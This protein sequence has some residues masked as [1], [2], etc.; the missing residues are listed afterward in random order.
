[1][2]KLEFT[3][4]F[5]LNIIASEKR[6]IEKAIKEALNNGENIKITTMNAQIAYFYLN[7]EDAREAIGASYVIPDGTGLSWA[8]RRL[9]GVNIARYP[10]V[11]LLLEICR[12]ASELSKKAYILGGKPGV[13]EKAAEN[14]NEKTGINICGTH[15]GYF[16]TE[17]ETDRIC[18]EIRSKAPSV[19]FVGLGAPKQEKWIYR[20]FE[21]TGCSLAIGVGGSLDIYAQTAKRAPLWIQKANLEWLYRILQ[22]PVT[23]AKVILQIASFVM[24]VLRE[25]GKS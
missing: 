25:K 3:E 12:S 4:F 24:D 17:T 5:G 20:N 16:D 1:M 22:H 15:D 6:E 2:R 14:L 10:G 18:E 13:A 21:K 9:N 23:K 19:L 8:L 11:E 7:F